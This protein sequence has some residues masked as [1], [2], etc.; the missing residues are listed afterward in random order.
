M[1]ANHVAR[2][3]AGGWVRAEV[4][5][6]HLDS[7]VAVLAR[8]GKESGQVPTERR[9][10]PRVEEERQSRSGHAVA[11]ARGSR[12]ARVRE[13]QTSGRVVHFYLEREPTW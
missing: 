11:T 4:G 5:E 10:A 6:G 9:G 8:L 2:R 7:V 1:I 12:L 13:T 3:P